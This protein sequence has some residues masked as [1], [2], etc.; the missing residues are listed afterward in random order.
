MPPL[1]TPPAGDRP[2]PCAPLERGRGGWAKWGE[3]RPM[4]EGGNR[5]PPLARLIPRPSAPSAHGVAA[6]PPLAA[7]ARSL[8]AFRR[9]S[10]LTLCSRA[11]PPMLPAHRS[12]CLRPHAAAASP[13]KPKEKKR[14][15]KR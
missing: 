15:G 1:S 2:S 4:G 7:D 10:P 12:A 6:R 13:L 14:K 8:V 5:R 11:R 9:L 3:M